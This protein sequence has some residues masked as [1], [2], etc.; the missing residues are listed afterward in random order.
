MTVASGA[1]SNGVHS[2]SIEATRSAPDSAQAGMP[3]GVTITVTGSVAADMIGRGETERRAREALAGELRGRLEALEA[4]LVRKAAEQERLERTVEELRGQLAQLGVQTGDQA[5]QLRTELG[6]MRGGFVEAGDRFRDLH[7]R[8]ERLEGALEGLHGTVG[9]LEG[10]VGGLDHKVG[11]LQQTVERLAAPQ[12]RPRP[13]LL[14][15]RRSLHFWVALA[16]VTLTAAGALW[17][18]A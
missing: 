1:D 16:A 18:Y 6:R 8:L 9:G 14:V 12:E 2:S 15:W 5:T 17:L 11:S 4:E 13:P 3:G 10:T 7:G